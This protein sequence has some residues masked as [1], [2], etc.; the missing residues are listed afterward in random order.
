MASRSRR[1]RISACVLRDVGALTPLGVDAEFVLDAAEA[2]LE[3]AGYGGGDP[4]GMPV[5][6]EDRTPETRRDPTGG[7][8]VPQ[9]HD[10]R[11]CEWRSRA[12]AADQALEQPRGR[13]ARGATEGWR[14]RGRSANAD[15]PSSTGGRVASRPDG[16]CKELRIFAAE[17]KGTAVRASG[18]NPKF[19]MNSV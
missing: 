14:N 5:E 15:C 10:R 12:R 7:T 9:D 8:A 11:R 1:S 16:A 13:A 2:F 6:S 17:I 19:R 3:C 18:S 4:A